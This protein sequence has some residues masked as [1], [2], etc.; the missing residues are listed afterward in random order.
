MLRL[1]LVS[2]CGIAA[3]LLFVGLSA[4]SFS[5]ETQTSHNLQRTTDATIAVVNG[6]DLSIVSVVAV[7]DWPCFEAAHTVYANVRIRNSGNEAADA[8]YVYL[9]GEAQLVAMLEGDS[10]ETL[11]FNRLKQQQVA[12]IDSSDAVAETDETNNEFVSTYFPVTLTPPAPCPTTPESDAQLYLPIVV[13]EDQATA[14]P[15][16][17]PTDMPTVQATATATSVPA[18]TPTATAI[19][20][21]PV[22]PEATAT[23]ADPYP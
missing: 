15:T 16:P 19:M 8:F 5:A 9:N 11:R 2:L 7:N 13:R 14:T 12:V 23:T 18:S 4:E 6:A 22:T 21:T 20:P 17:V 3:L 1:S 10:A